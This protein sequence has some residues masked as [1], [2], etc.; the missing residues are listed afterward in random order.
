MCA[1]RTIDH[2][3]ISIT[4]KKEGTPRKFL[5]DFSRVMPSIRRVHKTPHVLHR[6]GVVFLWK[7]SAV[8]VCAHYTGEHV[9]L[10]IAPKRKDPQALFLQCLY[11]PK[12]TIRSFHERPE[13]LHHYCVGSPRKCDIHQK[14]HFRQSLEGSRIFWGT[15]FKN[16]SLP[17]CASVIRLRMCR[18]R[19]PYYATRVHAFV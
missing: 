19:G 2:V 16:R 14:S 13:T 10:L 8:Y 4:P 12:S 7:R 9:W 18:K 6:F 15:K 1:R 11:K 3:W 5:A 17:F